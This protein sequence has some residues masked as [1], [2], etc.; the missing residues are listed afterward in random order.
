MAWKDILFGE[1][2]DILP[3]SG[4]PSVEK[5]SVQLLAHG[6]EIMRRQRLRALHAMVCRDPDARAG[7]VPVLI[8]NPHT[9]WVQTQV[10]FGPQLNSNAWAISEPDVRLRH[11]GRDY[12]CQRLLAEANCAGA[13][14]GCG[15]RCR[16]I[17][18][19]GR[20]CALTSTMSMD[21]SPNTT[22]RR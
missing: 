7:E 17:W 20:S 18:G 21:R 5:D 12:P 10:E 22:L 19:R 13:T 3:G 14:G 4:V 6:Q 9:F 11:K 15:W 1:F 2:H 8:A 16:S